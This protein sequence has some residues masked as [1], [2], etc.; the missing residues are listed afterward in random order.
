MPNRKENTGTLLR[1]RADEKLKEPDMYKVILHNDH[2]TTQE[3]VVEILRS[4]FHKPVPEAT[5]IMLDVHR[6]GKGIVGSYPYDI[7][8]TKVNQVLKEAREKE[9]PLRCTMEKA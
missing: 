3:F 2:Y 9:F 1:H 7:A 5:R 4:I 6:K 8:R